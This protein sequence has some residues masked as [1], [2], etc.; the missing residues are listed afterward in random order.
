LHHVT[1]TTDMDFSRDEHDWYG[2]RMWQTRLIRIREN[3]KRVGLRECP[4]VCIR[5]QSSI[6]D[7]VVYST[8]CPVNI[9]YTGLNW[10]SYC[11]LGKSCIVAVP[12]VVLVHLLEFSWVFAYSCPPLEAFN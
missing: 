7:N 9:L 8:S 12:S 6:Y 3:I 10:Q 4:Y 11:V 2:F 5:G 1:N